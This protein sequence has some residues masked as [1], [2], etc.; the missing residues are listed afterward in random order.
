MM[1]WIILEICVSQKLELHKKVLMEIAN[2]KEIN[3]NSPL[4]AQLKENGDI[5][6]YL[7]IEGELVPFKG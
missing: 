2:D 3:T 1:C 4:L 6:F 5:E 7:M